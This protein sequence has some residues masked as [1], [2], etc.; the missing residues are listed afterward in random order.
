MDHV[1]YVMVPV[2]EEFVAEVEQ[3]VRSNVAKGYVVTMDQAAAAQLLR[4]FDLPTRT[5]LL[6]VAAAAAANSR[7]MLEDAAGA[8]GC[9]EREVLGSVTVINNV[10]VSSGG[11][12]F[13]VVPVVKG[14]PP[15]GPLVME[16][17][18]AR[19]FVAAGAVLDE[20]Q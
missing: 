8:V 16:R 9:S 3:F 1:D 13:T 6:A 11:P 14:L 10:V 19:L 18:L 4:D 17:E 5:L 2:P 20:P 15:A 12:P 7:L